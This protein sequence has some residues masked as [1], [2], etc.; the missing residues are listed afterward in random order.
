M[1][2][3]VIIGNSGTG[4]STLAQRIGQR[5]GLP[6]VHMDALFWLPGWVESEIGPFRKR[7][8]AAHAGERWVSE[9]NYTTRTADLRFPQADTILWLR[10]PTWLCLLR[11][12]WRSLTTFGVTRPDMAPGCPEKI[13]LGFYRWIWDFD[14]RDA[15]NFEL[16]LDE[17][18]AHA[19]VRRLDSDA[20]TRRFL[21]DLAAVA[22]DH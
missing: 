2:R 11:A 16:L 13:D 8:A 4:K 6:V 15:V 18:A 22:D 10:R 7:V 3:V 17:H 19:W 14:R 20:D 5:L 21:E 9:G 1:R 12:M